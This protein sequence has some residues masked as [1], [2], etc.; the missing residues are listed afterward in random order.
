MGN[1]RYSVTLHRDYCT[2]KYVAGLIPRLICLEEGPWGEGGGAKV[3][4]PAQKDKI[5]GLYVGSLA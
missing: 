4:T 3:T 1:R 2:V 5:Y